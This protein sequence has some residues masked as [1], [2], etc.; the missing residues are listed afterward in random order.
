MR[1][2][3]FSWKSLAGLA[4]L[5]GLSTG[6]SSCEQVELPGD[7]SNPEKPAE[8]GVVVGGP[9]DATLHLV[10]ATDFDAMWKK[11]L[12]TDE[13]KAWK[14]VFD[15]DNEV[16]KKTFTLDIESDDFEVLEKTDDDGNGNTLVLPAALCKVKEL[17]V[18]F[19][20]SF[21]KVNAKGKLVIDFQKNAKN[22]D[23]SSVNRFYTITLPDANKAF[24][25]TM[26]TGK[27]F[28]TLTSAG[29]STLSRFEY[30]G[31]GGSTVALN[32]KN[33]TVNVYE[34]LNPNSYIKVAEGASIVALVANA[35][36]VNSSVN[37]RKASSG[38]W[39]AYI[40]SQYINGSQYSIKNVRVEGTS[41]VYVSTHKNT[42]IDKITIASGGR[43]VLYQA[44]VDSGNDDTNPYVN[45]IEGEGN[46]T[47]NNERATVW[48]S[49]L[50]SDGTT[51]VNN[52]K[53]TGLKNIAK[54]NNVRIASDHSDVLNV[55]ANNEFTKTYIDDVI[56]PQTEKVTS[57]SGVIVAN[58]VSLE[59]PSAEFTFTFDGVEFNNGAK[60]VVEKATFLK[61][62]MK[63]GKQVVV[64]NYWYAD[65]LTKPATGANRKY[66]NYYEDIPDDNKRADSTGGTLWGRLDDT[67]LFENLKN[68]DLEL[69]FKDGKYNGKAIASRY[70]EEFANPGDIEIPEFEADEETGENNAEEIA[71]KTA[72]KAAAV[73]AT[74]TIGTNSYKWYD[75]YTQDEKQ[76]HYILIDKD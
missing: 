6:L 34:I 29:T 25:L 42:P 41:N 27:Q 75:T 36:G 20:N 63:D 67:P 24:N 44:S 43:V 74:I 48:I 47:K 37:S 22:D 76:Y 56:K 8:P 64:E 1:K 38:N 28:V 57:L 69:V 14:K 4:L 2:N 30:D 52:N 65:D 72:A 26:K 7:P 68:V 60:A 50:K 70:V 31:Q 23:V 39:A 13:G 59:I 51:M 15:D 55:Y 33:T 66:T 12:T 49:A 9:A 5:I 11:W 62:V 73:Q 10:Y 46:V 45:E 18:N 32:L 58:K 53:S 3:I 16:V 35:S 21:A 71:A 17:N 19:T 40:T 61:P 54:I